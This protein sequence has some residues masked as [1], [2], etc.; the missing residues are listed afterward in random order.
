MDFGGLSVGFGIV[1]AAIMHFRPINFSDCPVRI[2]MRG[3]VAGAQLK[4]APYTD[5]FFLKVN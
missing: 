3:G 2:G 1:M 5:R 4:A